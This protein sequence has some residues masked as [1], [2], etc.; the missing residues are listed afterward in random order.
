[1]SATSL[2]CLVFHTLFGKTLLSW[3]ILKTFLFLFYIFS[4]GE[5]RCLESHNWSF[6]FENMQGR[7]PPIK[8]RALGS[9]SPILVLPTWAAGEC[10]LSHNNWNW[11]TL[12]C[13][14]RWHKL[15]RLSK[16]RARKIPDM[17]QFCSSSNFQVIPIFLPIDFFHLYLYRVGHKA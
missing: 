11:S 13:G 9:G 4:Q 3:E 2:W 12:S 5:G 7:A 10:C 8:I 14:L 17:K 16:D 1:M 6:Y 15:C